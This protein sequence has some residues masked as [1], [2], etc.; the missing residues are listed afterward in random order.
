[1][2]LIKCPQCKRSISTDATTCPQCGHPL[3]QADRDRALVQ[4]GNRTWIFGI[5]AVGIVLLL[6]VV[7]ISG[8]RDP[9]QSTSQTPAAAGKAVPAVWSE[10]SAKIACAN[11]IALASADQAL[12]SVE[13]A[14][15][16]VQSRRVKIG[17]ELTAA[18]TARN[19]T[20]KLLNY[21]GFCHE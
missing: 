18:F 6:I 20:A 9:E 7:S 19:S 12:V 3:S 13:L 17:W 4:A 14:Q 21:V 8:N 2:A 15:S 5:V 11:G 16:A 1:M 10:A